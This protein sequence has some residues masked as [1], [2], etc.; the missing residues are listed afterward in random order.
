MP[1]TPQPIGETGVAVTIRLASRPDGS[2]SMWVG[3]RQLNVTERNVPREHYAQ[4]R[5]MLAE[6]GN[7]RGPAFD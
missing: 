7:W 5:R 6:A 2:I 1:D 4:Y 3:G